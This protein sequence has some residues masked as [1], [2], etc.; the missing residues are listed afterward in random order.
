MFGWCRLLFSVC[1]LSSL[2]TSLNYWYCSYA[3]CEG[4]SLLTLSQ[5]LIG[6]IGGFLFCHDRGRG[7]SVV[8]KVTEV[9]FITTG[10]TKLRILGAGILREKIASP[11]AT[12]L[13]GA[14]LKVEFNWGALPKGSGKKNMLDAQCAVSV[15]VE[16]GIY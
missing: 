9:Y 1:V 15:C 14:F 10:F 16:F 12:L 7:I 4:F 8:L 2:F 11:K 5:C 6:L 13:A 3:L